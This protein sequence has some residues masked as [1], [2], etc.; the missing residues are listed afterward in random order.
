MRRSRF[1]SHRSSIRRSGFRY[2]TGMGFSSYGR[3]G[4][5]IPVPL[6][7]PAAII[8]LVCIILFIVFFVLNFVFAIFLP[9]FLFDIG[10]WFFFIPFFSMIVIF[11]TS[12]VSAIVSV[13]K[14]QSPGMGMNQSSNFFNG[15]S[16]ADMARQL[17]FQVTMLSNQDPS[18]AQAVIQTPNNIILVKVLNAGQA[19]QNG[20]VQ[21]LSKGLVT[22]QAKEAWLIQNPP[23][24]VENDL[25]FARFYNVKLLKPEEAMQALQSLKPNTP[26]TPQG[27]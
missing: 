12:F 11:I 8:I 3:T 10:I 1:R 22:Y 27:Q 13:A 7:G 26:P 16:I 23:T 15:P 2:G 14:G 6:K 19:Y 9:E 5:G 18:T 17:G 21:D 25:N 20:M 24:F 4:R